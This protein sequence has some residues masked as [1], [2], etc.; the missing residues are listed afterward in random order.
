MIPTL[1]I[2]GRPNVGK[3]TL[4][5]RLTRSRVAIVADMP[6]LTRDR[7]YGRGRLGDKRYLVVDTGG[8]EPV[9]EDVIRRSM[10]RQTLQAIDEADGV[11]LLVDGRQGL[12]SQDRIIADQLRK[13]GRKHWVVVNKAEGMRPEHVAAEF[14]ELAL[15][16]PLVISA[17]HGEGVSEL[18]DLILAEFPDA[19]LQRPPEEVEETSK[20]P[21]I[22][23]VGR[24]NAGKSTLVNRIL[25]E[26]RVVVSDVPGTT[27][28]SIY[29]DFE[30]GGRP[31]TLID[32]AGMRRRGRVDDAVEKFSVVKTMQAIEDA[33]VVVLVLDGSEKIVD[34]D[35]HIAGYV[36]DA[37]RALVVAV[38]KWDNLTMQQREWAKQTLA[39]TLNFMDFAEVHHISALAGTGLPQLFVS[40]E[41]A[42]QSAMAKLST[43]KLTRALMAAIAKQAPPRS[44]MFR[45]KMRYAH[46]GGSNP[47]RVIIHGSGLE[48]VPETYRRYLEHYLRDAFKLRGAPL[49]IE[50]RQGMNP[51]ERRHAKKR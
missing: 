41:R 18:A 10:A 22:A 3:S 19:P 8:F 39:R 50:F 32:T 2:I 26:D 27:R 47:P 28:D 21:R 34:Q 15:G 11:V 37:G 23:V 45:P 31:Y 24:P 4:F 36:L 7:H 14:H 20:H 46:Q 5:N 33:N 17:A 6:G 30:R 49:K 38:N 40:I 51:Y 44:G 1:V 13:I 16:D 42:Y 12:T 29:V 9:T 35:A 25:G 43:P 48:K